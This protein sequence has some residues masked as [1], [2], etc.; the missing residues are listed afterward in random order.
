MVSLTL[1]IKNGLLTFLRTIHVTPFCGLPMDL[2]SLDSL[3]VN[4]ELDSLWIWPTFGDAELPRY[5][6]DT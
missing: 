6:V 4:S 2:S 5:N 3:R 1:H